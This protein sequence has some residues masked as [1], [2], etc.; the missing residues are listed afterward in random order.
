MAPSVERLEW[1]QELWSILWHKPETCA[2]VKPGPWEVKD[3]ME[4][5]KCWRLFVQMSQTRPEEWLVHAG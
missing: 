5:L 4:V 1:T 2:N 3:H